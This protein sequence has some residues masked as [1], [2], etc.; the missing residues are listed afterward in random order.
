MAD[1]KTTVDGMPIKDLTPT[2]PEPEEPPAVTVLAAKIQT[3]AKELAASWQYGSHL[4]GYAVRHDV[5]LSAIREIYAAVQDRLAKIA[6]PEE[7]I[8]P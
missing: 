2:P 4:K 7:V 5:P 6:K 1:I 8:E 3:I